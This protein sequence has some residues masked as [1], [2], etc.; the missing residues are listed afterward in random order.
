M[1]SITSLGPKWIWNKET[2]K[3]EQYQVFEV[4]IL[5]GAAK[6]TCIADATGYILRQSNSTDVISD[7][8]NE[9]IIT[10]LE[11]LIK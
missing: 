3:A 1:P 10:A 4:S 5:D 11:G 2:K 9:C 7:T 6:D 8:E